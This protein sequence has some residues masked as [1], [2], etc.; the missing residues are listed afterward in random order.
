MK[1][2][3]EIIFDYL[4]NYSKLD[5]N[6]QYECFTT[7][8]LADHLFLERSSVSRSLNELV[9]DGLVEK[10]KGKPVLFRL[11]K[12]HIPSQS[13]SFSQLIGANTV[14]QPLIQQA[15]A[16]VLYP[17][18]QL[19]ILLIGKEGSGKAA[20]A[21]CMHA[22]ITEK[23]E[24]R[25]CGEFLSIDCNDYLENMDTMFTMLFEGPE[26]LLMKSVNGTILIKN[27]F[28]ASQ[29]IR[30][31]LTPVLTHGYLACQG[32]KYPVRIIATSINPSTQPTSTFI[33]IKLPELNR[34]SIKERFQIVKKYLLEEAKK[35]QFSIQV[36]TSILSMFLLYDCPGDFSQ[37][38]K[39]IM[40]SCAKAYVDFCD[41]PNNGFLNLNDTYL[42]N[43]IKKGIFSFHEKKE[44]IEQIL[45]RK[46]IYR[47]NPEFSHM[48]LIEDSN[49]SSAIDNL[50]A[51]SLP[52]YSEEHNNK[53]IL[54]SN[55]NALPAIFIDYYSQ[56]SHAITSFADLENMIEPE[57]VQKL[58]AFLNRCQQ[59]F[60][61]IYGK[62]ILFA[63][64]QHIHSAIYDKSQNPLMNHT[65]LAFVLK[66]YPE[67]H[68]LATQ[69]ALSLESHYSAHF[70]IND[71]ALLS[72]F[73]SEKCVEFGNVP[74]PGILILMH[75][76][77]AAMHMSHVVNQI[78]NYPATH[79]YDMSLDKSME[80]AYE[81]I[82]QLVTE[83][84]AGHGVII[85]S[86]MGA[87]SFFG[88]MLAKELSVDI[89]TVEMV[90]TPI[91]LQCAHKALFESDIDVIYRNLL[92]YSN[93]TGNFLSKEFK[94]SKP[95]KENVILT[96][97]LTGEGSAI[98]LKNMIENSAILDSESIDVVPLSIM[99][100]RDAIKRIQKIS[101]TSNIIAIVGT[102]N[103]GINNIPFVSIEKMLINN[104]YSELKQ[105]VFEA[106][107]NEV[108]PLD[109]ETER[110][111]T[112][113]N[114]DPIK[115]VHDY[116]EKE[117]STYNYRQIKPILDNLITHWESF[118]QTKYSSDKKIGLI[119]HIASALENLIN[120][121]R[122]IEIKNADQYFQ[123]YQTETG[124][125][126]NSLELLETALEI[127]I[128][129]TETICLLIILLELDTISTL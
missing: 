20:F 34:Y 5:E 112:I 69:F 65:Q 23:S 24:V 33:Q 58:S 40:L 18:S 100:H 61:R 124:E 99:N 74:H 96:I 77:G 4:E 122:N 78:I 128:P 105:I 6:N 120:Q 115:N 110:H 27:Y 72:L 54:Y 85:L 44:Q 26:S 8:M 22:Y 81:E 101:K 73:L 32:E 17:K 119:V 29:Q 68:K 30:N 116:L 89:R 97:C 42:S 60:N 70:T 7:K 10:I 39:D 83:I 111:P 35:I 95:K 118:F 104:N 67:E 55:D 71:I 123:T 2:S 50:I 86:D 109:F 129:D 108:K 91:A 49:S 92:S 38:Q 53:S 59:K 15:K 25:P 87:L 126:K 16:S 9:R 113:T 43:H 45:D 37:L 11:N 56:L 66:A 12:E 103:P 41:N 106:F 127:T 52:F 114:D 31:A 107:S 28:S 19:N 80:T 82:K 94:L 125:I 90:S 75:G 63:L 88:S 48:Q 62:K 98:K 76:E 57:L 3:K 51:N 121:N 64:C 14:L 47:F 13:D 46:M 102:Y 117:I 21:K 36:E 84:D 1:P 93:N 79:Y